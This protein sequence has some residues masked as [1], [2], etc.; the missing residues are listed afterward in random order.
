MKKYFLYE[1]RKNAFLIGCLT[2]FAS[3]VYCA[4][5]LTS[6]N[7]L[8]G[9]SETYVWIISSIGGTFATIAPIWFFGSVY[10]GIL[11]GR[12]LGNGARVR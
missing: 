9:A 4:A 10:R 5:V 8:R 11:A 2:L 1:L 12:I 3:L 6:G 7:L